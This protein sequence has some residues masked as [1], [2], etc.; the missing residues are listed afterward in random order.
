M[1]GGDAPTTAYKLGDIVTKTWHLLMKWNSGAAFEP[2]TIAEHARILAGGAPVVWWGKISKSGK[3]GITKADVGRLRAQLK[4]SKHTL[5]FLYRPDGFEPS[6]LH[7]GRIREVRERLPSAH[8]P[9]YYTRLNYPVRLWLGLDDIKM[10]SLDTLNHIYDPKGRQFDPVSANAYPMLVEDRSSAKY[11]DYKGSVKYFELQNLHLPGRESQVDPNFVFVLMPFGS[12]FTGVWERGI[13]PTI[14]R[15]G[16][17][18]KRADDFFHNKE[19]MDVIRENIRKARLIVADMT[20]QNP[21]V[22]YELGYAH[23]LR[24]EVILLTQDRASVPFDLKAVK[25]IEYRKIDGLKGPLRAH[26]KSALKR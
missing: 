6:T 3:T 11:F 4:T 23:A 5:V 25:S 9:I 16:L 18:C 10:I 14:Q 7:V 24:K 21:N 20:D 19:I 13:R 1:P 26:V 17:T 15:L 2:D 22:F 12:K 8:V